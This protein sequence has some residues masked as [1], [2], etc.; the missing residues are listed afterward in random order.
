MRELDLYTDICRIE[1]EKAKVLTSTAELFEILAAEDQK[2]E[3]IAEK[4]GAL[5]ADILILGSGL[6][7]EYDIMYAKINEEL[8]I[9]AVTDG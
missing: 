4:I 9:R 8:K 2:T 1:R 7:L 6:G 5:I 3:R